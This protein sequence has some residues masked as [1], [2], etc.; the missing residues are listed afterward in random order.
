MLVQTGC[1]I[2]TGGQRK[3][4]QPH[5]LFQAAQRH[6]SRFYI[7]LPAILPQPGKLQCGADFLVGLQRFCLQLKG[8]SPGQGSS[9]PPQ[10]R[11][12]IPTEQV[13]TIHDPG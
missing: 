3:T 10:G 7:Q 8:C 11:C 12:G 2:A 1:C 13:V 5:I 6:L 9:P 4:Q